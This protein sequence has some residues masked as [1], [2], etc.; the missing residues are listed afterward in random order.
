[1]NA[2]VAV[3][4]NSA[5]QLSPTP[6]IRSQVRQELATTAAAREGIVAREMMP[7]ASIQQRLSA[8]AAGPTSSALQSRSAESVSNS[9]TESRVVNEDT[10]SKDSFLQLL[11][12]QM[13]NQDP[14]EP[15]DN[16]D[17]LAQLA[18]FSSL[19]AQTNLNKSFE[20]ISG[21]IDQLN[22]ISASQ[23]L[24]KFV[25]GVDI[26]GQLHTGTV[27]GVHLDGS[28]VVLTVDGK[29]MTMAGVI[30]VEHE[31]PDT[32]EGGG[33]GED[34]LEIVIPEP[35]PEPLPGT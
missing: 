29:L 6:E 2:L 19:E 22:F 24:G 28:L 18:Q 17:M 27:E 34:D 13:Q 33:D 9:N 1:M 7:G 3:R 30:R 12:L 31:A 35:D 5:G 21:N 16:A 32:G 14:L 20:Q 25:E 23:M 10:L 8:Q 15:M 11:V 26:N 4:N